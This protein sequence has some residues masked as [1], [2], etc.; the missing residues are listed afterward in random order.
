MTGPARNSGPGLHLA[1]VVLPEAEPRDVW[2]RDGRFTFEPV[3]AA[4]T[5]SR[6]GWLLPG[7][8]DAHC[9]VGVA[10]EGR[11]VTDPAE[12]REQVLADRAAGVLALRDCGSPVDTRWLDDDP[13]LPRIIRAGRP[14]SR[15][16]EGPFSV[17]IFASVLGP[18]ALF[19]DATNSSRY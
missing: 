16:W 2:V 7:L 4:A 15:H 1:G 18:A 5:V 6:G 10:A 8:V 3:P 9:H 17:T 12:L 14:G 19:G 11:H 13:E